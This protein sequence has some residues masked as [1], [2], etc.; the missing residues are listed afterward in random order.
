MLVFGLYMGGEGIILMFAPNFLLSIMGVPSTNEF[1]VKICGLSLC[2]F[3]F[4]YI[5]SAML[6]V[7]GF[8]QMTLYG[9]TLQLVLFT[10][11]FFK[12]GIGI[13]LLVSS[14]VEFL[15]AIWTYYALKQDEKGI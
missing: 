9:R 15:S 11:L 14:F 10:I 7:K 2:V 5:R 12:D 8:F 3:A 4:Y 1:W 13:M 6:E